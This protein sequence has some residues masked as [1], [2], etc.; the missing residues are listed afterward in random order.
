MSTTDVIVNESICEA[1]L[2][3]EARAGRH[4]AF[5]ELC[6]R[7]SSRLMGSIRRLLQD[8]CDAEDALQETFLSVFT[9]LKNFQGRSSL[10]TWMTRVAVNAALS[11]LRKSRGTMVSIDEAGEE[12][13]LA[14]SSVLQDGALDAERRLI[15]AQQEELLAKAIAQLPSLLRSVLELRIRDGYSGKQI[16]AKMDISE[17]AVKSRL[18]RAY[19][20]L[21]EGQYSGAH[22]FPRPAAPRCRLSPI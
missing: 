22:A 14:L 12:S 18:G 5:D 10:S 1:V 8:R 11:R 6:R 17:S 16:A 19:L 9:H 20:L 4:D 7:Y 13:G 15:Q 2:V 21:R 3:S